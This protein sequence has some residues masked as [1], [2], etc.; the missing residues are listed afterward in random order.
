MRKRGLWLIVSLSMVAAMLLTACGVK[1][2]DF[3]AAK[4]QLAT[5]QQ[6]LT[7]LKAAPSVRNDK[8]IQNLNSV[9]PLLVNTIAALNKGDVAG[10]IDFFDHANP[11]DYNTVWH[12]METY[13]NFRAPLLY[14]ELETVH[15]AKLTALMSD[16]KAKTSDM[17][18]EAGIMLALWDAIVAQDK[19]SPPISPAFDDLA[20]IRLVKAQTLTIVTSALKANDTAKAKQLYTQFSNRW[21]EVE[22]FIKERS[23]SEVYPSIEGAMATT[24]TA[25]QKTTPDVAEMT[26]LTADLLAKYNKGQ[27]LVNAAARNT[28]L[29]KTAYTQDDVQAGAVISAMM[30]ELNSSLTSWKAANYTDSAARAKN[31]DGALLAKVSAALKAKNGADAALKTALDAYAALTDKAGDATTVGNSEEAAL[32]ACRVAQQVVVGQFWTDPKLQDA[33]KQ[34]ATSIK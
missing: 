16:P 19:L 7:A 34:A 18:K 12:G 8:E 33:I 28:D 1:Q 3:D 30:S 13:V 2:A 10:A 31:A 4:Q 9:R 11:N 6:Q 29:T 25:Y 5:A 17:V 32:Q 14:G 22:D 27:A 20:Q 24:L 26:A 15:Q 21:P 23:P